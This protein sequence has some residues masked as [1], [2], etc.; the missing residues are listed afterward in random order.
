VRRDFPEIAGRIFDPDDLVRLDTE[1]RR[2]GPNQEALP[3]RT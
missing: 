2:L 3:H 1:L